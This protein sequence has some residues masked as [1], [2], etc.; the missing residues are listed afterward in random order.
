MT[1]AE[2]INP[3]LLP[4]AENAINI[5]VRTWPYFDHVLTEWLILLAEMQQDIGRILIGQM[6]TK[7]KLDK[8]KAISK[9]LGHDA[10]VKTIARISKSHVH[11]SKIRNAVAHCPI[12][13]MNPDHPMEILFVESRFVKGR[14]DL[15]DV[16][17]IRLERIMA[18]AA[19]ASK[20]T[21]TIRRVL[22]QAQPTKVP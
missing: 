22:S 8:L 2:R 3:V 5:L 19:F 17:S 20:T 9:H 11:F 14:R 15:V 6:E 18:A 12:L 10:D 4:V 7:T 1:N 13:G 21:A 16:S